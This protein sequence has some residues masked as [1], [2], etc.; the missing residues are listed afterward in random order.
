VPAVTGTSNTDTVSIFSS[1]TSHVLLDITAFNVGSPAQINP[2]ILP[3]SASSAT[4]RQ[5]TARAKA[6]TLPA[7]YSGSAIR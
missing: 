3:P 1:T 6:G 2:A 4:N 5:L 7:W